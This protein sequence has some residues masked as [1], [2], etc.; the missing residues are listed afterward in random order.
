MILA[1]T[2][3]MMCVQGLSPLE[4]HP[5]TLAS[6]PLEDYHEI[7]VK[8]IGDH[9]RKLVDRASVQRSAWVRVQ[10]P[11]GRYALFRSFMMVGC[12]VVETIHCFYVP[13]ILCSLN[14]AYFV[15]TIIAYTAA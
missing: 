13:I 10:G 15:R 1:N 2:I 12:F 7:Y 8:A 11:Y 9:T 5:Y 3:M 4:W 14:S 6:S